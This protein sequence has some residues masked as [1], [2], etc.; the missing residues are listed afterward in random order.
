MHPLEKKTIAL[1]TSIR[2]SPLALLMFAVPN[3]QGKQ[4]V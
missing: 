4:G 2:T 3:H 1:G